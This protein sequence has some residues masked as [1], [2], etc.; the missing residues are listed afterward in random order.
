MIPPVSVGREINGSGGLDGRGL[1]EGKSADLI[2][3][4][5]VAGDTL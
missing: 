3:P 1:R 2:I 4:E 5:A